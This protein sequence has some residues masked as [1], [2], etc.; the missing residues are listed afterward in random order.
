MPST[1]TNTVPM[2]PIRASC[3]ASLTLPPFRA[4]TRPPRRTPSRPP[5]RAASVPAPVCSCPSRPAS[6]ALPSTPAPGRGP[7]RL[8]GAPADSVPMPGSQRSRPSARTGPSVSAS[9]TPFDGPLLRSA[10]ATAPSPARSSRTPRCRTRRASPARRAARGLWRWRRLSRPQPLDARRRVLRRPQR[11]VHLRVR[12]VSQ[13]IPL[14][15]RH[16]QGCGASRLRGSAPGGAASP[17]PSRARPLPWPGA[18]ARR[19][20]RC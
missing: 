3:V 19:R 7:P 17:P 13:P 8:P 14:V 18:P 20:P 15:L 9:T 16:S 1:A 5:G 6:R 11:R 2:V 10:T 12:V 4:R